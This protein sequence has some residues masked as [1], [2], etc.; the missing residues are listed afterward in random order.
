MLKKVISTHNILPSYFNTFLILWN[1]GWTRIQMI[2]IRQVK[3]DGS[4]SLE[5]VLKTQVYK[6]V[7]YV[8]QLLV[9]LMHLHFCSN[10][11]KLCK[12]LFKKRYVCTNYKYI[13]HTQLINRSIKT[14]S[15]IKTK[16]PIQICMYGL[17]IMICQ[18]G[19]VYLTNRKRVESM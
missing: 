11:Y 3:Y 13:L 16:L 19:L 15:T 9:I 14:Q 2:W 4:G 18:L 5:T 8:L 7:Y 10:Y 1:F 17:T 6:L 12:P